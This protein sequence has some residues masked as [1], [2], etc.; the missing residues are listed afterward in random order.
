[1]V[2]GQDLSSAQY[3]KDIQGNEVKDVFRP[4]APQ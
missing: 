2:K 4:T 3:L 1:M